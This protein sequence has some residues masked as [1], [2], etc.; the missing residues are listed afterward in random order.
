MSYPLFWWSISRQKCIIVFAVITIS[1]VLSTLI[2]SNLCVK[3]CIRASLNL[4]QMMF[5]AITR[6]KMLFFNT[7]SSGKNIFNNVLSSYA[8]LFIK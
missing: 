2:R 1:I 8:Y 4:H 6:A 3:I 5:S 7:N